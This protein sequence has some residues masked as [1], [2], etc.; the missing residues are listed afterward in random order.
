MDNSAY[1][2]KNMHEPDVTGTGMQRPSIMQASLLYSISVILLLF[3][4]SRAQRREFY[5]GLLVTEF[6]LVLIPPLILLF[7]KKYDVKRILRLNGVSVLNLFIIFWIMVFSIPVVNILNSIYFLLIKYTFGKIIFPTVPPAADIKTLLLNIL[8]VGGSAGIC[9]EILFRGTLLKSFERFGAARGIL[10]TSFLFGIW[11]IYFQS[12]LGTFLLGALIGFM[13]Y[14]TNS[15]YSGMF[16]HFT[17]NTIAVTV[18]Y[19]SNKFL[20]NIRM[21]GIGNSESNL[22]ADRYFNSIL[23]MPAI[24]LIAVII[25]WT[26]LILICATI[27]SGLM[28]AFIKTTSDKVQRVQAEPVPSNWKN[29]LWLLPGIAFI[30]LVYYADALALMGVKNET[31]SVLLRII[32]LE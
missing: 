14:R 18:S 5:S 2:N 10:L 26:F 25:I 27:L 3:V 31:V 13:V 11:H 29:L 32:G 23:S 4:A 21:P 30:G 20:K 28:A 9:E 24:Q 8:V 1:P 19:L 7:Y 17:N 12:F 6:V 16:A 15:L 22:D